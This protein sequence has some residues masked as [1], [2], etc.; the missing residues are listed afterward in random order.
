MNDSELDKTLQAARVPERPDEYWEAFPQRVLGEL[1][2]APAERPVVTRPERRWQ[3]R[4]AWGFGLA[5]ACLLI[6][7][8][9]F[10]FGLR[11]GRNGKPDAFA[12]LQN[13]HAL[14]EVLTL[15]P[16]RVRAIIQDEHGVQLVLSEQADVPASTPLWIKVC[17]GKQCRAIVTF[18]GQELQIARDKVEVLADAQGRIVLVGDRLFWSSAEPDRAA[19]SLRIQARPLTGAM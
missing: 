1:R 17:D 15:F 10:N 16:N 3:P 6:G 14:R 19:G 2:A 8:V 18:S 9:S 7:V 11:Q 12:W 4:L 5:A 13:E